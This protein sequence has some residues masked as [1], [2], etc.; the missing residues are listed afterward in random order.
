MKDKCCRHKRLLSHDCVKCIK[1]KDSQQLKRS[2]LNDQLKLNMLIEVKC[3]HANDEKCSI[4][5]S[6]KM[7]CIHGNSS[8]C[9][10]C[11]RQKNNVFAKENNNKKINDEMLCKT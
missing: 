5:D 9:E 4:Q 2:L 6:D 3:I 8:K 11:L 7:L 1:Y 10:K